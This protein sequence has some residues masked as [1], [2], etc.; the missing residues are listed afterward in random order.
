[1]SQDENS[2]AFTVRVK[3]ASKKLRPKSL[4][5]TSREMTFHRRETGVLEVSRRS[6]RFTALLLH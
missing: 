5:C 4:L 6:L 1:M 3:P 2:V